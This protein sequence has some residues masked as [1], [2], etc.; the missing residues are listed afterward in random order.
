MNTAPTPKRHALSSRSDRLLACASIALLLGFASIGMGCANLARS[1]DLGNADVR[2][3]VTAKQVC[4]NCHGIDGNSVSPNFPRLAAQP[5]EY[6]AKELKAF[7]SRRR[8][9]PA[10][11]DYM[12]GMARHL[13]DEQ[14]TG[15]SD[16]FSRQPARPNAPGDPKQVEAG[17]RIYQTGIAQEGTPACAACHGPSGEG[18]A[19]TPR[20]A[21][22]HAAYLVR[23]LWEFKETDGR[24][25]SPMKPI[26][27]LLSPE[28]MTEVVAYLQALPVRGA[29]GR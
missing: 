26:C 20:L 28:D 12:W 17:R 4:A 15:L 8:S 1:R 13:T 16:Y 27:R 22:Q 18:L 7:R 23:E 2:P 3:E 5:K 9:D 10:A 21:S 24:P 29:A 14:I 6:L 19:A 25:D 11:I